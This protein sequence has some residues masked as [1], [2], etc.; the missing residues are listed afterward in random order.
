MRK[1]GRERERGFGRQR[2]IERYRGMRETEG[3]RGRER[4][5]E[6]NEEDRE[7]LRGR[8]IERVMREAE[9]KWGWEA[10]RE[11]ELNDR[12]TATE[13]WDAGMEREE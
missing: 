2:E 1:S 4:D 9:R 5:R 8:E 6:R 13:E 10:G 11:K 7:R 12:E 3:L